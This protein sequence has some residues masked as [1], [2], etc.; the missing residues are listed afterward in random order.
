MKTEDIR[1]S[2]AIKVINLMIDE[3]IK[4]LNLY[5][6]IL[7]NKVDNAFKEPDYLTTRVS[8]EIVD[9]VK[10][11]SIVLAALHEL[12]YIQTSNN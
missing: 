12:L 11:N 8:Y 3:K 2:S 5:L 9:S 6:Y 4:E 10:E 1:N 7:K